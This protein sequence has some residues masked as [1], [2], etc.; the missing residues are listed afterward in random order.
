M[1]HFKRTRTTLEQTRVHGQVV[2]E[3]NQVEIKSYDYMFANVYLTEALTKTTH[4]WMDMAVGD[5]YVTALNANGTR[6][7]NGRLFIFNSAKE[8]VTGAL[9]INEIY[10]FVIKLGHGDPDGRYA[11]W[12]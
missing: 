6:T 5:L 9:N 8:L 2:L 10:T 4:F 1:M 7:D 11:F 12:L 3:T